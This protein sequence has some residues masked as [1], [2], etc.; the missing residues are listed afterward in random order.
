MTY[1]Y[2][3]QAGLSSQSVTAGFL[4]TPPAKITYFKKEI[5]IVQ[6]ATSAITVIGKKMAKARGLLQPIA[7]GEPK[8]QVGKTYAKLESALSQL[9]ALRK[10]GKEVLVKL[11]SLERFMQSEESRLTKIY[12]DLPEGF[13]LDIDE[14]TTPTSGLNY[15]DEVVKRYNA[16]VN[17]NFKGDFLSPGSNDS[18]LKAYDRVIKGIEWEE[19]AIPKLEI[20]EGDLQF[21]VGDNVRDA[22]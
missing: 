18:A 4:S 9:P 12:M 16:V 6:K 8:K 5:D 13:D 2:Q 10:A 15:L 21:A 3:R 22:F 11:Y 19:L 1:N 20:E 14:V 7:A 17:A